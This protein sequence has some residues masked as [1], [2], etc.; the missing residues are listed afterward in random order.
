MP[1]HRAKLDR[2]GQA[3][4]VLQRLKN[5]PPG[6]ARERLLAVKLGIEGDLKLQ[7][8]AETVGRSRATIQTWFDLFRDEG[9]ER[10]CRR[11][12]APTGRPSQLTPTA[13]HELK[14]KLAKG[15]FRKIEGARDWLKSRFGIEAEYD[16][17][18]HWVGKLG[19]RLKVVQPRHPNNCDLKRFCFQTQLARQMFGALKERGIKRGK[20]PIRIWVSDEARFGLQPCLRRAWVTR[21]VRA[22]KSSRCRYDWQYIWGALQVGGGGSEFLYTNGADGDVSAA[23]LQQISNRDP[24]AIHI[25]IWDGASFHPE[26]TDPRIPDNVV[27]LRQPPYSPELNPVEKLWDMLRDELCNRRWGSLTELLEASTRWL[28]S[29]WS[30]PARV[31][32]LVGNGWMRTQANA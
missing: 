9:I 27:V 19:A 23:F 4:D 15:S 31:L 30:E 1:R 14:K 25:M 7:Q 21:G 28:K 11:S 3:D 8:I 2:L 10:L 26:N 18:R 16:T 13:K 6:L 22:H 20:R 32:S 29:F 24:Y 5:E 17:V 12:N